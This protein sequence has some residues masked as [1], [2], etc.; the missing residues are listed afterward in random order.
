MD[1]EILTVPDCPNLGPTRQHLDAALAT[2]GVAANVCVTEVRD[3]ETAAR[4]GMRG[5]PTVVIDGQDAVATDAPEGTLSC[6]LYSSPDGLRGAPS[7][8][9]LIQALSR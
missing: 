6:R 8:D 2:V 1:V 5:S 3:A 4:T 7:V 9:Q